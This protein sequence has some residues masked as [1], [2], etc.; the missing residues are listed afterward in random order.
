M[1]VMHSLNV[2]EVLV[3]LM[4]APRVGPFQRMLGMGSGGK[5]G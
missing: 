1:T 5:K 3:E 2:V 4:K